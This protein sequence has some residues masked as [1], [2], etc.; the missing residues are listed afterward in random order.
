MVE[1]K[2]VSD[3][4][5]D[6]KKNLTNPVQAVQMHR[7]CHPEFDVLRP[8]WPLVESSSDI[9]HGILFPEK[10]KIRGEVCGD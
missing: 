6:K 1:E 9:Y 3:T 4:P 8:K 5:S 10:L 7:L 2:A